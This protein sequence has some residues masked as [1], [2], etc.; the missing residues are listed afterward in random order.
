MN[1]YIAV[2]VILPSLFVAST[3]YAVTTC[4]APASV[5]CT[6][7]SADQCN[8]QHAL[9]QSE[10]DT[11]NSCIAV[12][13]ES[14][15]QYDATQARIQNYCKTSSDFESCVANYTACQ[16]NA[17]KNGFGDPITPGICV[18][19]CDQGY[20]KTVSNTCAPQTQ[21]I[22]QPVHHQVPVV[23]PSTPA[24]VIQSVVPTI[25][26]VLPA[27][28][29]ITSM[30]DTAPTVQ[31]AV[32]KQAVVTPPKPVTSRLTSTSTANTPVS[33]KQSVPPAPQ[34]TFWNRIGN[35]FKKLNPFSWF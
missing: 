9:Y 11:Y 12:N 32:I 35:L 8:Q 26:P 21:R 16:I 14:Q 29:Q 5:D 24:P 2:S 1:K 6:T 15:K 17:P 33:E 34:V 22:D 30:P 3:A 19:T 18:Y 13:Y 31:K 28:Q 7:L 23:P 10:A 25:T 4:Y 27:V 20:Y